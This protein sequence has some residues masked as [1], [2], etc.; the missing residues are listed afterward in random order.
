M[1]VY[2]NDILILLSIY[3][4]S[5]SSSFSM[6]LMLFTALHVMQMRY[7]DENSVRLSVC[8]SVGHTRDP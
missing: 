6:C 7:S 8:P 5:F 4:T 1:N 2:V 3:A